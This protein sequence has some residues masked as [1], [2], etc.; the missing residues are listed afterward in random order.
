RRVQRDGR[1]G[2]GRL[3]ALEYLFL[4][5][6]QVGRQLGDRRRAPLTLGQ[7]A[8]GL[9]QRELELLQAAR[10]PDRP[11]LVPE[12]PLDLADDGGRGVGGEL[13]AALQVEPVDRL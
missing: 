4:A 7:V 8:D 2:V 10:Y 13:H 9:G 1:V 3:E 6:L 12:V 11:A 5:H